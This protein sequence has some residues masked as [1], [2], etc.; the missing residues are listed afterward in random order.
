M[1]SLT[2]LYL[3]HLSLC[4][5][6]V[7]FLFLFGLQH[8]FPKCSASRALSHSRHR[9]L[10]SLPPSSVSLSLIFLTNWRHRLVDAHNVF[11]SRNSITIKCLKTKSIY[12]KK[13]I[14]EASDSKT[15]KREEEEVSLSIFLSTLLLIIGL[16]I[17][18][19]LLVFN[20]SIFS[21]KNIDIIFLGVQS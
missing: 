5:S 18:S 16:I 10:P 13:K 14:L 17:F 15:K 3:I 7:S 1:L 2:G 4:S 6:P 21:A 9:S 12:A 19:I 20:D 11:L 8:Q